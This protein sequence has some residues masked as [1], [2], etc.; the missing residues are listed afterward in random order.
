MFHQKSTVVTR[1]ITDGQTDGRSND[2][3]W[4]VRDLN[5]L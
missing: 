3:R 1:T 2:G 5:A 4:V